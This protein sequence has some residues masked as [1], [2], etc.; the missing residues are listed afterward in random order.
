[1]HFFL[2]KPLTTNRIALLGLLLFG[3]AFAAAAQTVPPVPIVPAEK[4]YTYVEQMPQLPGGGG[5]AAIV[6][7]IQ[8]HVSYPPRAL[9][10]HA[11]GR[12]FVSFTVAASGLVEEVGVVKGLRPDCDSMVVAAVQQLPRFRPGQQAG[13]AVPVRFTVPV[14]FRLGPP[15]PAAASLPDS[16]QRVYTYIQYMPRYQGEEGT[17]KLTQDLLREF[18]KTSAEAGCPLPTF[19]V[20]VTFIVGPS[21]TIYGVKSINNLPR[22]DVAPTN[23]P[24]A[25]AD[26][27][28]G[29]SS[30]QS[31]LQP[32]PAACEASLVAAARKLP[33]LKPG[34][35]SG[36]NVAVSFTIRLIGPAK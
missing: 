19:P 18:E 29:D 21:G 28:S 15:A 3:A 1:M 20:F 11:E 22:P 36:R 30:S 27:R 34:A 33:R 10:A 16:V 8:Q 13:K 23:D 6:T 17:K 2:P 7:A 24:N 32:L 12:V 4:V 9:R 14:T 26:G 35:Q 5:Q 31:S 25:R